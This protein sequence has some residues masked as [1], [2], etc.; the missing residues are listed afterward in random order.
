MVRRQIELLTETREKMRGGNGSVLITSFEKELLPASC[1]LFGMLRLRPGCSI[2]AHEHTGEAEMF[3]FVS[4]EGVVLDD[5]ERVA[6]KA[7]DTMTC[8][9]GHS[10][11][12][13]NTGSEDLVIVATIAKS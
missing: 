3:Y 13:E 11:G 12:V 6:V 9:S 5:G 8:M 7:G 4:G 1:R 2:G 10:H